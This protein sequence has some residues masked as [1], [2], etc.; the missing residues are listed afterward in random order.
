MAGA[1]DEG[2]KY[3]WDAVTSPIGLI[4]AVFADTAIVSVHVTDTDPLWEIERVSRLLFDTPVHQPGAAHDLARQVDEYF[5]GEREN[6]ELDLD[7]RL[8]GDGFAAA[9]LRAIAD[10]PYGETASYGEIAALAGRPRAARAV[11][12]ACRTTPFSLVLPVH[13]VIRSDGSVGEYGSSPDTKH[14]LI[15][16]ERRVRAH[17]DAHVG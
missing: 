9:A 2:M 12:S 4:V 15:D 11:G 1:H 3:T 16:L 10:I 13:R 7:W 8:A 5:R 17:A 6:F 14:F